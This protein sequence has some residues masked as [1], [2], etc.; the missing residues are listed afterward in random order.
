MLVTLLQQIFTNFLFFGKQDGNSAGGD[1]LHKRENS[2]VMR[3][4]NPWSTAKI[5]VIQF[6]QE[7]FEQLL[8]MGNTIPLCVRKHMK[9]SLPKASLAN[10]W[11]QASGEA[12]KALCEP[13]IVSVACD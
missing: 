7:M 9:V 13:E 1:F 6:D 11:K 12:N 4:S 3:R 5:L 10:S 8:S 2:I